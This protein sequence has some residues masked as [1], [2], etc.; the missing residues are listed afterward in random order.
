MT[1]YVHIYNKCTTNRKVAESLWAL[2]ATK[3]RDAALAVP[4]LHHIPF[5]VQVVSHC[6][7]VSPS[8]VDLGW[9]TDHTSTKQRV[10]SIS[11]KFLF[12]F[13]L[14]ANEQQILCCEWYPHWRCSSIPNVDC[15]ILTLCCEISLTDTCYDDDH[16]LKY[17]LGEIMFLS[18]FG[19]FCLLTLHWPLFFSCLSKYSM[20]NGR[21][22][23]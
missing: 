21:C 20:W 22:L 2:S 8:E 15:F 17:M 3:S 10:S 4:R 19:L 1:R 11:I 18:V 6:L 12:L 9:F 14:Y 16:E 5:E 13:G 7:H 23:W